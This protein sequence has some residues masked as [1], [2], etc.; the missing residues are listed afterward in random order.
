[1]YKEQTNYLTMKEEPT[2]FYSGNKKILF[3]DNDMAS[4]YLV[5]EIL[6]EHDIEIIYATSGQNAIRLF[7]QNPFIDAIITEIKVPKLDGFGILNE[8]RKMN[9]HIPVLVQTANVCNE[10]EKRC[11]QAGFNEFISKPIDIALFADIV[12]KYVFLPAN[13]N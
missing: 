7:R 4:Y 9:P 12:K 2:N 5:S 13:R 8:I 3:V 6:K 1:M 11:L 10:I